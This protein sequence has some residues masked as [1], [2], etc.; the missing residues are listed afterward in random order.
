MRIDGLGEERA[1]LMGLQRRRQRSLSPRRAF[2]YRG[3]V[4][5]DFHRARG[6]MFSD[7]ECLA[8]NGGLMRR[9]E[10]DGVV[11]LTMNHGK[12]N[13]MDIELCQWLIDELSSA[14]KSVRAVILTGAGSIFCAGVDLRKVVEGGA[15]YVAQFFPLLV[16]TLESV[17]SCSAAARGGDQRARHRRRMPPCGRR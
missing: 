9:T 7:G 8:G 4:I 15:D 10:S 3:M 1:V 14:E 5:P 6:K 2:S 16:K 17:F 13:A 11:T 12:A